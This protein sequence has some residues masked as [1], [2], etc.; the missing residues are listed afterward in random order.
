[1]KKIFTMIALLAMSSPSLAIEKVTS[2]N[3]SC[4][5]IHT[6]IEK[7]R[8]VLLRYSG[9]NGLSNYDRVVADAGQCSAGS[10][11]SQSVTFPAADTKSCPVLV[12]MD[13]SDRRP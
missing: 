10:G 6:A 5:A 12:C 9:A 2:T 7:N 8:S 3:I 1:M 11:A 13:V 4:Q